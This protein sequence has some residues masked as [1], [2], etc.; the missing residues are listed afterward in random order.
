MQE[1]INL[2]HMVEVESESVVDRSGNI[3]EYFIPHHG[4][5]QG[6]KKL[7]VVFNASVRCSNGQSLNNQLLTGPSLQS[8]I[9]NNLIRWRNVQFAY[10]A[11][12]AK[13]YRQIRMHPEDCKFQNVLWRFS[14]NEP[15]KVYQLNTVTYGIVPSAYHAIRCLRQLAIDESSNFSRNVLDLILNNMYVDDALFGADTIDE[16]IELS[17]EFSNLLTAGGF[18]LR[19]WSANSSELL[20]HIPKDWLE[21]DNTESQNLFKEQKLLGIRWNSES[22]RLSFNIEALK[23]QGTVTKR[24]VLSIIASLYDP[25]GLLSPVIIKGKIFMQIL[26]KETLGWDDAL[27]K[28]LLK[29][30]NLFYREL[31]S[32]SEVRI[33]RWAGLSS[34]SRFEIHGFSDASQQ[35]MCATIYFR[36]LGESSS[37]MNLIVAKTRVAP[38][39]TQTIPRLELCAALILCKLVFSLLESFEFSNIPLH[40]WSD[41]TVALSWI[42]SEPHLW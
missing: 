11:D 27:S 39:K 34:H 32:V 20:S 18:P 6:S 7:R 9:V 19:K 24:K 36:I 12:I 31:L 29:K 28:S 40:L 37:E 13:M 26:W 38:L 22:D 41:S 23:Y 42:T 30:W 21:V 17:K 33:P 35:A 8:S 3:G 14:S 5:L 2:G 10:H 16:A 25:L 1:F 4:V 15:I